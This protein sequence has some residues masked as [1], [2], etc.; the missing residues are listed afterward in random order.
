VLE[1]CRQLARDGQSAEA[2]FL[3]DHLDERAH[4]HDRRAGRAL[5][6]RIEPSL[7]HSWRWLKTPAESS[8]KRLPRTA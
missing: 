3:L 6:W 2:L 1:L 8:R 4:G 7:R 5:A